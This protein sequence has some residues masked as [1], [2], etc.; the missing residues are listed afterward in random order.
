MKICHVCGAECEDGA[1]LCKI[2][3]ADL[4]TAQNADKE[5]EI[6]LEHPVLLATLEDVVSAEILKDLLHENG[7]PFS[8]DGE[9]DG[10]AM[11][12]TF[13]GSFVAEDIYVDESC[14]DQ[15]ARIYDDF[16]HEEPAFDESFFEEDGEEG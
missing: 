7:I 1:E 12:V 15:A 5:E 14:F 10:G 8:C 9:E 3:G 13:G 4:L 2:C 11:K 6:I 16:L